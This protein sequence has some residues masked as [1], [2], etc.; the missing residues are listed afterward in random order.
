MLRQPGLR[1]DRESFPICGLGVGVVSSRLIEL[2]QLQL[3][4]RDVGVIFAPPFADP[5]YPLQLTMAVI[6]S[7]S[8]RSI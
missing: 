2:T 4:A 7:A 6:V 1:P 5:Q 8:S 3:A